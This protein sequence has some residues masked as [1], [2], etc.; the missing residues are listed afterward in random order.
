MVCRRDSRDFRERSLGDAVSGPT[1]RSPTG[2]WN[3]EDALARRLE[4]PPPPPRSGSYAFDVNV[5]EAQARTRV[6]RPDSGPLEATTRPVL[7][8]GAGCGDRPWARQRA[9]ALRKTPDRGSAAGKTG[10]RRIRSPP[11]SL[12]DYRPGKSGTPGDRS[13]Q[14][15]GEDQGVSG[16]SR[17]SD[18][19]L[20]SMRGRARASRSVNRAPTP[21]RLADR[22]ADVPAISGVE[23]V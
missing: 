14:R 6:R 12:P 2:S 8:D 9:L 23:S 11:T 22:Q 10:T 4:A 19:W 17:T 15:I 5:S 1:I 13:G 20:G 7:R 21:L 18:P 16:P 3:R